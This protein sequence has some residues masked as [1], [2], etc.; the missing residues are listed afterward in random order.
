M[1]LVEND[2]I[3]PGE[4]G[5][6]LQTPDQQS[7][8]DHLDA[9]PYRHEPLPAHR[10][11]NAFTRLFADQLRHPA[12]RRPGGDPPGLRNDHPTAHSIGQRKRKQRCLAGARRRDQDR[13]AGAVQRRDDR[14]KDG[15]DR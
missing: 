9:G 5:V 2:G 8:G 13:G 3:D 11:S 7:R 10:E 4:F 6:L 1:D 12:G 14:R 15:S